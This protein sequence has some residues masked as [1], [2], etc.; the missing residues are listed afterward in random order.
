ME[1]GVETAIRELIEPKLFV[2][3]PEAISR[4]SPVPKSPGVYAWYFNEPPPGVPTGG[5]HR[6]DG[7][8]LLYA[9]ISPRKPRS[10]DGRASL[11]TIRKRIRDHYRRDA[12]SST[13]RMSLGS[14]LQRELGLVPQARGRSPRLT[15]GAGEERLSEWMSEHTK[16]CWV[17]HAEPWVVEEAL[18]ARAPLA[19]NL[20]QNSTGEFHPRLKDARLAM[21]ALY[22]KQQV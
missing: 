10:L 4:T 13:L 21:R 9:G 3:R 11:G 20:S 18:L 19:L 1:V 16:V 15:F 7:W 12:S 5:A 17:E 2:S 22:R 8:F 14:L 6:L